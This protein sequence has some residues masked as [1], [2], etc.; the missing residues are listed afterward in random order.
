MSYYQ[1]NSP[2]TL[3]GDPVNPLHVATK[4]YVDAKTGNVDGARFQTGVLGVDKL[5]AL[6]GDVNSN[7]GTNVL[8]LVDSGVTAG[9]K[10]RVDVDSKGR[11]VAGDTAHATEGRAISWSF[12]TGKPTTL[13]GYGITDVVGMGGG[14]VA[15]TLSTSLTASLSLHSV[16]KGEVDT[17]VGNVSVTAAVTGDI[18]RSPAVSTPTGFLRANGGI[19][20]KTTYAALYAVIGDTYS[21]AGGGAGGYMGQPWRQQS[22]FNLTDNG[23]SQTWTTG[24]SLP[25]TV[26]ES[27]ALITKTQVY[28]L[29]GHTG[30]VSSSTVYTAP[31]ATDGTL[32]TWTTATA[33]PGTV[34]A[35]QAI[36]TQNRVYLLG[37][38]IN[39][40]YSSTVYTAPINTDGTL[41]TWTTATSLPAAVYYSQAIATKDRVYLLGGIINSSY[42]STVYTAPINQDGTLGTW[43]TVTPLPS[44]VYAS[45]A[46]VT[47]DWVYL[48]G[49]YINGAPSSTVYKAFFGGEKA[50]VDLL[51]D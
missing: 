8:S 21:S 49:G 12:V 10:Y 4:Q 7:Q 15:G 24:T 25:G 31:I 20:G 30:S 38:I 48:L 41:G 16:S 43:A 13:A 46:I 1:L 14:T 23:I 3:V 18:A 34:H 27:Q 42:S 6:V 50:V 44:T 37:G 35:S 22:A 26:Y 29:G 5:P 19:V 45:Q 2:L 47:K 36:V 11:I 39:N 9:V 51:R 40:A 33:L 32:G 28:L 17:M